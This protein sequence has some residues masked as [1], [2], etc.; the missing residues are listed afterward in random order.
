M[1]QRLVAQLMMPRY[2]PKR[3]Q[4]TISVLQPRSDQRFSDKN[5]LGNQDSK[6]E[7]KA[8]K[9]LELTLGAHNTHMW[10]LWASKRFVHAAV[11]NQRS[12]GKGA[13]KPRPWSAKGVS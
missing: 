13:A 3:I 6:R 5:Q 1:F 10:A 4:D 2:T 9:R 7:P 11:S 8:G 12:K